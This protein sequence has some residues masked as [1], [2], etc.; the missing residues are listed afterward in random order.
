VFHLEAYSA[1]LTFIIAFGLT[2]AGANF[3]AGTLADRAGRKPV[4]VAGWLAAYPCLSFWRLG[5]AGLG[6]F[7]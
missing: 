3:A 5:Q 1:A 2:K 4:L 6:H 7:R